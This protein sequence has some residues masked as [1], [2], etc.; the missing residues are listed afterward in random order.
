MR[1]SQGREQDV[2]LTKDALLSAWD[3]QSHWPCHSQM[4]KKLAQN[5]SEPSSTDADQALAEQ[6]NGH[7]FQT[8]AI[9]KSN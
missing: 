7:V 5:S 8:L 6:R 2:L 3:Q 4:V 1:D 9:R